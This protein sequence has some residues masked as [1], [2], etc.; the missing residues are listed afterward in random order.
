MKN[1]SFKVAQSFKVTKRAAWSELLQSRTDYLKLCTLKPSLLQFYYDETTAFGDSA[2]AN[3]SS[4]KR[5][6]VP[7]F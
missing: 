1:L 6:Y 7:I 5:R 3:C 2:S 4:Y